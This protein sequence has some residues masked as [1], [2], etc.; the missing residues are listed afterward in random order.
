MGHQVMSELSL[1][2]NKLG[3][4]RALTSDE[5]LEIGPPT[6]YLRVRQIAAL[7]A[8]AS[9]T[10]FLLRDLPPPFRETVLGRAEYTIMLVEQFLEFFARHA[11]PLGKLSSTPP[12]AD[13]ARPSTRPFAFLASRHPRCLSLRRTSVTRTHRYLAKQVLQRLV[14]RLQGLVSGVSCLSWENRRRE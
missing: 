6:G 4:R 11:S 14:E 3:R 8:L 1:V 7:L 2:A 12:L 13:R 9:E 10:G 5:T